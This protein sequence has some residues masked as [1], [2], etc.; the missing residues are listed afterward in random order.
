MDPKFADHIIAKTQRDYNEIAKAFARTREEVWPEI[1]F[2]KDFVEPEEKVL[3]IGCGSGRLYKLFRG[4]NVEYFGIDFAEKLID[5]AR[6]QYVLPKENQEGIRPVFLTV[7]ALKLPFEDNFFDKV[8]SIAVFHH[9]P[10]HEKRILFLKEARRVLKPKGELFLTV[11]NLWQL[12]YFTP[13]LKWTAKK[14]FN[15][16]KLDFFDILVPFH[17]VQRY[18]HCFR[19]GELA[20]LAR[21]AYFNDVKVRYLKRDNKNFNIFL[22]A[23]K[24]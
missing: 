22:K 12:K 5:F 19:R 20:S 21:R 18:H 17:G 15:L 10:S 1:W 8:F 2:F 14:L 11:W 24:T 3:D 4:K 23:K 6:K 13:I 16:T 7:N 9:V